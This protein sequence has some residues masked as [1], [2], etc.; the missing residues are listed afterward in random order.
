[1]AYTSIY[2][3][4]ATIKLRAPQF[5][6][7]FDSV[8]EEYQRSVDDDI[9]T[10]LRATLGEFDQNVYRI[11]LPLTGTFDQIDPQKMEVTLH[12]HDDIKQIA[13]EAVIALARWDFSEAK[14]RKDISRIDIV[15]EIQ[16]HYGSIISIPHDFT[17]EFLEADKLT[18]DDGLFMQLEDDS[19][20]WLWG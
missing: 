11:I 16:K 10:A 12:I 17:T 19:G 20:V 18:W 14:E 6:T 8:L 2:S 4:L 7:G 15:S 9:T 3:T 1:M 5:N 13:N